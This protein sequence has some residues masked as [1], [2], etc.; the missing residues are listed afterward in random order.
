MDILRAEH[1][2]FEYKNR[3]QV[4]RV[5][6]D[7]NCSFSEGKLYAIVGASG[8]GK[9]TL[10][11]LLAGLALPT[12]GEILYQEKNLAFLDRDIYRKTTASVIYQSYNLFP[13]L[14][15]V[16]NVMFPMQINKISTMKARKMAE[17][18]LE[19]VGIQQALRRK[20]PAMMSGGE[21]QRI[22]IARALGVGGKII[23][24]D[25]PTGNLDVENGNHILQLFRNLVDERGYC[26]ILVTH[27]LQI[28]QRADCIYQMSD[29]RLL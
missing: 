5:L 20:F 12:E 25:E 11:S 22:A 21:Q 17:S 16:E 7:V 2:Y 26:V 4:T 24:A 8:S 28:A 27:D 29:G 13:F 3:Y 6:K 19:E 23:L 18:L 10:L 14:T 15:A 1:V 9:T